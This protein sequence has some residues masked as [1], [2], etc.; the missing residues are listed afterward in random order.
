[1]LFR[2]NIYLT[3]NNEPVET[4][5]GDIYSMN[6]L[7][8]RKQLVIAFVDSENQSQHGIHIYDLKDHK[9]LHLLKVLQHLVKL[10]LK[11]G[12]TFTS[13]LDVDD[14]M[15]TLNIY[16]N[17]KLAIS[18]KK[19]IVNFSDCLEDIHFRLVFDNFVTKD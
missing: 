19:D 1:M 3:T 17:Q 10:S 14:H 5:I 7:K 11:L 9:Y 15:P 2:F 8:A 16:L 6:I 12:D 18:A 4:F 13:A